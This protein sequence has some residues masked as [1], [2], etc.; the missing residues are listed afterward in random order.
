MAQT[1]RKRRSKHRGNAAGTVE[2]R[3][4]TGRKPTPEE[5]RASATRTGSRAPANARARQVRPM[6]PPSWKSA[7]GKAA[8]G[9]IMLFA[10][11]RFGV[12]GDEASTG[13]SLGVAGFAAAAY[14]PVMYAT[15]RFIYQRRLRKEGGQAR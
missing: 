1:K 4:R 5:L 15:D 9:A 7:F 14:T 10:L 8:F 2:A 3:G 12:L 13:Q 6:T 11:M